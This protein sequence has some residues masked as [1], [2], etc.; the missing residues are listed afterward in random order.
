M[1]LGPVMVGVASY[2]LDTAERAMLLHPMVG[3]VILF[4]RNYDNIEQLQKL[5]ADIHHLREPK[6]LVCVD[7]EGGRVQRFRQGFSAL[8]PVSCFGEVYDKNHARGRRLAEMAGWL[9]ASE[10]RA[11]GIDFSFAPVLDLNFGCSQVIGDRSFHRK[12]NAVAELAQ[13]YMKGMARAGMAAT[14]K[15]FPGHGAVEVD[16]HAAIARDDRS[17][18]D[19][20]QDDLIPFRR[21]IDNGLAA[22]MPAHVIYPNIDANPAGFSPFWLQEVLRKRLKFQGVIFSD[23]LLMDGAAVAGSVADRADAALAAGCDMA[24]VCNDF[25]AM[26]AVLDRVQRFD[27]PASHLRLTRMKGRHPITRD[28]LHNDPRWKVALEALAVCEQGKLMDLL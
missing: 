26:G 28:Q 17:Y 8:P 6:L 15:H 19:I 10:L 25:E 27:N 20:E 11:V 12:P 22:L 13:S 1:S 21:M 23:D 5:V 7:H 4:T 2:E 14:G 9:M 18:V 16:T 24:L 3:A